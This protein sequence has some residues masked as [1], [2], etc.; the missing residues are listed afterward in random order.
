MLPWQVFH[1][2]FIFYFSLISNNQNVLV[3]D[4]NTA[5]NTDVTKNNFYSGKNAALNVCIRFFFTI[6]FAVY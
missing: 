1:L 2:I 5:V 4:N 3:N 6:Y